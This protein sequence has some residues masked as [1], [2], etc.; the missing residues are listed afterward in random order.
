S[1]LSALPQ[2]EQN[3]FKLLE[4]LASAEDVKAISDVKRWAGVGNPAGMA[5]GHEAI[6]PQTL[7]DVAAAFARAGHPL[8]TEHL[9]A[10]KANRRLSGGSQL[11]PTTARAL[12]NEVVRANTEPAA[13]Y[14]HVAFRGV[15]VNRRTATMLT[16]AEQL[17]NGLGGPARFTLSQGSYHPGVSKSAG[18]HDGGGVVDVS[19]S[20]KSR[21]DQLQMVKALRQAGFAAWLRGSAENMSP[22]IHAVA[23]GDRQL[24]AGARHQVAEYFWGG[25][26]LVGDRSDPNRALGRPM[27]QWARKYAP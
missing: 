17:S 14:T 11:G 19:V 18:T 2:P 6:G 16:R 10:F 5:A 7:K 21:A 3:A 22:H 13:D 15:T 25:D 24:A 1:Q 4:A 23:I 26:G 9:N 12:V 27:P 20:G 8:T